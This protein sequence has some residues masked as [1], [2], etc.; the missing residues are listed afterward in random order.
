MNQF[1]EVLENVNLK[2]YN[3]YH[4][5]G[6]AKYLVKPYDINNLINLIDYLRVNKI[7]YLVIG[8][9]SNI[10]LSDED[11]DGAIIILDNL[12][13]V[14]IHENEVIVEAGIT[15]NKLIQILVDNELCGIENLYGVP[16]TLGGAILQNIE[17]YHT[18]IGDFIKY[19]NFVEDGQIKQFNKDECHF[20]YRNSIFRNDRKKIIISACLNLKTGNK[21]LM[22]KII[23]EN[24]NKR[25]NSQPLDYPNAGSVFKNFKDISAG[26]LI[27]ENGLKNYHVNG[28]YISDKHANFIINKSNATSEDIKELIRIVTKKIKENT[29]RELKLEQE[30]IDYNTL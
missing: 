21:E 26:K 2:A 29:S 15:I 28:A 5:G 6:N 30:I 12:N 9:G 18:S 3:T 14:I 7:K 4:I 24:I 16:G 10:I 22:Q 8:K 27:D 20:E 13:K 11:F 19:V 1:G 17:V 25:K 23:K